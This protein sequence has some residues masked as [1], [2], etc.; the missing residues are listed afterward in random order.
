MFSSLYARLVAVLVGFALIMS[1]AFVLVMR[2][3]DTALRQ[4]I[5][6][7][8]YRTYASQL[9]K[10]HF[11]PKD[12]LDLAAFEAVFDHIKVVNQIGRASWR[13]RV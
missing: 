9:V 3:S 12:R 5:S 11:F 4:E 7:R 8:A 10:E 1:L 2:H 13:E 6:Q